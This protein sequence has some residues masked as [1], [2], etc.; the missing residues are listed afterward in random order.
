MYDADE[1]NRRFAREAEL[2][3]NDWARRQAEEDGPA[4]GAARSSRRSATSTSEGSYDSQPRSAYDDEYY[5]GRGGSG[6]Y[7]N[8]GYESRRY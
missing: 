2:K 7:D 5:R 6:A 4:P 1:E 8:R 3:R